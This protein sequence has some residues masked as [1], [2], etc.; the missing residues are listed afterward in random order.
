MNLNNHLSA[1]KVTVLL[2]VFNDE[3]Y[4]GQAIE[5][6]LGQTFKD[7]ELLIIDDCS[8]DGTVGIIRSYDD[9]RIRL[10][11]NDENIDI[12][13]SLN[14]GLRLAKG[15]YIARHDS[16]DISFAHRLE[17][18]VDFLE[19]NKDYT[20]VGSYTEL[21]DDAANHI[22]FLKC[23]RS[24]EEIYYNLSYRNNLTSSSMLFLKEAI[25]DI[26]YYDESSSHSEDYE[27]WFRLSRKYKIYVIAEYLIKYRIRKSQRCDKNY[28][29]T[30]KRMFDIALRT[31]IDKDLLQFL[32]NS[33][34]DIAF[35]ERV[36]LIKKLHRFHINIQKDAKNA[37]L[38][39]FKLKNV[40]F[41]MMLVFIAKVLTGV[42]G[43]VYL[44]RLLK[45]G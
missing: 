45:I 12:T 42:K 36:R 25:N 34:K 3:K 27:F 9:L 7:F 11:V 2:S 22:G 21:I 23:E 31:K 18:Q 29:P 8:T 40:C 30:F 20:A 43:K 37:G 16:D 19:S 32:Q 17:K 5:S 14:K 1:P 41:K 6:I 4:I 33:Q 28:G 35:F 39:S 13:R 38:S 24:A 44:K 10:V 15:K 26:G